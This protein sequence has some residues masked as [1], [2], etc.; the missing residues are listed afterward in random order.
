MEMVHFIPTSQRRLVMLAAQADSAPA[1]IY[2]ASGTGKSAIARWIH[3]NGPRSALPFIT[4][5]KDQPLAQQLPSAQGGTIVIPEIGSYPLGD[6][7]VLLNFLETKAIPHPE[8]RE[9]KMLLNVRV[10]TTTSQ[11]LEGRAQAGLFNSELLKKLNVFRLEMPDLAKRSDEFE[12]IVHG[13]LGEITGELHKEHIKGLSNEAL[14]KLRSY[15]WPGNLREL[16][17][18]LRV[19]VISVNGSQ[20][21]LEDLP[22][23]GPNRV[24]FHAT[25]EE[26]EKTYILELLKTFDWKIDKTCQVSRI[27]KSALLSKIKKYGIDTDTPVSIR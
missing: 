14:L 19:S 16:R 7:K 18:V 22:D 17:N 8:N 4:A 12:D 1:L 11:A 2:G 27:D 10:I 9:M 25:R 21:E 15:N 3:L 13:I 5:K 24:D 26:F 23:F 20:I 6:Q